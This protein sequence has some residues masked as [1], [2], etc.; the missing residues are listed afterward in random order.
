MDLNTIQEKAL[1]MGRELVAERCKTDLYYLCFYILGGFTIM[2]PKVHGPLCR[3][4]RPLLY[5]DRDYPGV[6]YPSDYGRV[7]EDGLPNEEEKKAILEWQDRFQPESDAELSVDDKF[8]T[9]MTNL[10]ALMPR[11]T[12]KSSI[13]TIGFTIQ[14][15]LNFP[16]D[17][18]LL[19]SETFSK[20]TAFLSE[21]RGHYEDNEKLREVFKTIYG[22]YPDANK[23]KDTWADKAINLACR[24]KR[25]KEES[26]SCAGIDVTKNG[27]HYDLGILDDLHSEKNTKSVEQIDQVKEHYKLV[28][29]LMDPGKPVIV[30]GTRWDYND[31]YQMIIDEEQD[32]Y[33]FM[34]RKAA[35][36]EDEL[37]YPGRLTWE[38]LS[39]MRRKQGSYIFSCQYQNNP[40]DDETAEFKRSQFHYVTL[41]SVQKKSM[42][43]YGLVDPSEGGPTADFA[44]IAIGGMDSLGEIYYR[45]GVREKMKKSK[46][47]QRMY[48]LQ[49]LMPFI[50]FWSVEV[51]A[52]KSIEYGMEQFNLDLRRQGRQPLRVKYIKS[53]PKSKEDRIR[54]LSSYYEFGRAHHVTG[55]GALSTLED[56]LMKFP[57]A[58]NDDLSDTWADIL[59]VGH[60]ASQ[61]DILEPE[62]SK[63]NKRV[64]EALKKPR[65]PIIGT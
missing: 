11:G 15:H 44:A 64:I 65:S 51:V 20:S 49:Q 22:I 48:E 27:M 38:F 32:E 21:I 23:R 57:K 36:D 45:F 43:W 31:L 58:K 63:K 28:Y 50:K 26:I 9:E 5:Y 39:M 42:H 46:L 6:E 60:P 3:M 7:E 62:D 12:L 47:F 25:R 30:V 53:R 1:S 24:S 4:T 55:A 13:L 59:E 40:I 35:S 8:D 41:E 18:I 34:T 14:W 33:N 52:Q 61:K 29:S 54:G 10:L 37:F 56:E 16:E 2:D 17:R 19:D